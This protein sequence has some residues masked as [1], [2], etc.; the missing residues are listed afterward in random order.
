[1]PIM[2]GD[3]KFSTKVAQSL[4]TRLTG[5]FIVGAAGA[6]GT[7]AS[8]ATA[9]SGGQQCGV[10]VS[11]TATGDYR[12]TLHR[13]Y[14]RL[15]R[16]DASIHLPGL[17][18]AATGAIDANI[19]GAVSGNFTGATPVTATGLGITTTNAAGALADPQNPCVV[20]FDL[21]LSDQ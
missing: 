6:V 13:G 17:G 11:R 16:G 9:T 19:Q 18:T 5:W 3:S 7:Q 10:S 4:V 21:E 8:T 2:S 1:M 12:L 15:I 20:T 14:K